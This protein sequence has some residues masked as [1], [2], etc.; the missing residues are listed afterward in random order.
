MFL[1][2]I[3][4]TLRDD[5]FV[6]Q[7]RLL[8]NDMWFEMV[9]YA[10]GEQKQL[11]WAFK[12]SYIKMLLTVNMDNQPKQFIKFQDDVLNDFIEEIKPYHTK[13]R[14][15]T[16]NRGVSDETT[17][18]IEELSLFTGNTT[19]QITDHDDPAI[20]PENPPDPNDPLNKPSSDS[21]GLFNYLTVDG[22]DG[23]SGNTDQSLF[24]TD[25]VDLD[26]VYDGDLFLSSNYIHGGELAPSDLRETVD[27]RVTTNTTGAVV[28]ANS[29][30]FRMFFDGNGKYAAY[31]VNV[32][33]TLA[34]SILYSDTEIEVVDG[35]VL[36]NPPAHLMGTVWLN[37][38]RI[39]YTHIS[40]NILH[41]CV[42]G[43]GGTA[44]N[45]H[46]AGDVVYESGLP[47][48]IPSDITYSSPNRPAFNDYGKSITD[49][50]STSIEAQFVYQN[51]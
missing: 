42:R 50:T 21:I 39:N 5:I 34:N 2:S 51:G 45:G 4:D 6:N 23:G 12:T 28:D 1:T 7:Y 19:T 40:N 13:L 37:E 16:V 15:I 18:T 9:K 11:D 26:Y 43:S 32:N 33:T 17:I 48:K 35:S 10:L 49:P 47:Y 31:V 27:I 14:D 36:W 30:E 22:N 8:Y 20:D 24:T 25:D 41:N 38:E 44:P 29:R 46:S 3:I